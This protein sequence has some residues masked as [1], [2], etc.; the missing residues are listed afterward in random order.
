MYFSDEISLAEAAKLLSVSEEDVLRLIQKQLLSARWH[1]N[2]KGERIRLINRNL[3][4]GLKDAGSYRRAL[5]TFTGTQPAGA[6]VLSAPTGGGSAS[7]GGGAGGGSRETAG[8]KG[9]VAATPAGGGMDSLTMQLLVQ[10]TATLRELVVSLGGQDE[11]RFAVLREQMDA[12]DQRVVGDQHARQAEYA[13]TRQELGA[14]SE[15]VGRTSEQLQQV[16][17]ATKQNSLAQAAQAQ[18]LNRIA[19]SV[20]ELNAAVQRCAAGVEELNQR[21]RDQDERAPFAQLGKLIK[22]GKGDAPSG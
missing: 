1:I 11:T 9:E 19:E 10:N 12:L 4:L 5:D 8:A 7:G 13:R 21:F 14:V 22:R 6:A 2:D 15:Q 3:V 20:A 18:Q 16:D 17:L